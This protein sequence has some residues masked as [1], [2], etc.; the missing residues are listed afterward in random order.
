MADLLVAPALEAELVNIS[1]IC[2]RWAFFFALQIT[3]EL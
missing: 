3:I 2:Q 1:T